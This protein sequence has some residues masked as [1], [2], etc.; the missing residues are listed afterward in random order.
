MAAFRSRQ[1]TLVVG[2]VGG[3]HVV[4]HMYNMLL[5]PLTL[6]LAADFSVGVARIGLAIGLLGFVITALQLPLGHLSDTKGRTPV[7][8][9]S[10]VCG[11]AGAALTALADSYGALLVAQ[12]VTGVGVAAHHP[13]HYPLLSA[14]TE[15]GTRGRA[16]SVHSFTGAVGFGAPFGVAAVAGLLGVDW[17]VA[18][19]GIAAVGGLY[20]VLCLVAVARYVDPGIT[21]P[22]DTSRAGQPWTLARALGLPRRALASLRGMLSARGIVLL[23]LLWL[24]TS[25][26]AWG[27]RT[28]TVPLLTGSY[29]LTEAVANLLVA[30]MFALGAV[31]MFAGGWLADRVAVGP[32]LVAGYAAFVGVTALLAT[33]LLPVVLAAGLVLVLGS[34]VDYSRPA[35]TVLADRLSDDEGVGKS[36][37]LVTIGISGGGAV[38]PPVLGVVADT[39][40]PGAAFAAMA[41]V[42]V[43]ALALTGVVLRHDDGPAVPGPTP[44]DD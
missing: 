14:A 16:F 17:R 39:A 19:G 32:V 25:M 34:T 36:F 3:S 42:G 28:Q 26:A 24:L 23:T 40:G 7:L 29:G 21:A 13:A 18:V 41:G 30:G 22:S 35:R 31:L 9:L 5:P 38:A 15:P 43:A 33:G 27:V 4:N 1:A 8:A 37:G 6:A 10:L 11:T 44:S 12:V 20:S 2:L